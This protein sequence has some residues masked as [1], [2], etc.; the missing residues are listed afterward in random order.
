M[1]RELVNNV[2]TPTCAETCTQGREEAEYA[3]SLQQNRVWCLLGVDSA[4]RVCQ[5]V[6]EIQGGLDINRFQRAVCSVRDRHEILRT[7]FRLSPTDGRLM[8]IV[9]NSSRMLNSE[10]PVADLT[11]ANED[12]EISERLDSLRELAVDVRHGPLYRLQLLRHQRNRWVLLAMISALCGDLPTLW[13]FIAEVAD[14]YDRGPGYELRPAPWQYRSFGE[15]QRELLKSEATE[16]GRRYWRRNHLSDETRF[17]FPFRRR[18]VPN[19]GSFQSTTFPCIL[20]Q[21]QLTKLTA[22][23][24]AYHASSSEVLLALWLVLLWR[25]TGNDRVVVGIHSDGRSQDELRNAFGPYSTYLP[26]SC[27]L[28]SSFRFEDVIRSAHSLCMQNRRWQ[29]SFTWEH[30]A[31]SGIS[32]RQISLYSAL[33]EFRKLPVSPVLHD[34]SFRFLQHYDCLEPYQAKLSCLETS[35]GI[36]ISL[37]FDSSSF[38]VEDMLQ[39]RHGLHSLMG[40][41]LHDPVC[42]ISD[43]PLLADVEYRHLSLGLNATTKQ[44][45]SRGTIHELFEAR[46]ARSPDAIAAIYDDQ[47]ISYA[48]LNRRANSLACYLQQKGISQEVLV[49]LCVHRSIDMLVAIVAVLKAGGAYVPLDPTYPTSCLAQLLEDSR[50][51]FLVTD[52]SSTRNLP[53]VEIQSLCIDSEIEWLGCNGW[54]NPTTD[55]HPGNLVYVIYTSGSTGVPKGVAIEHRQLVNYS[56]AIVDKLGIVPGT[57]F[58]ALSTIAADL[59]NTA[60]FPSLISGGS[61]HLIPEAWMHDVTSLCDYCDKNQIDVLKI[62][63]SHLSA[64]QGT[65]KGDRLMPRRALLLGGESTTTVWIRQ[66]QAM[67]ASCRILNHY[68]P[69]ETTVG[70]L[71]YEVPPD[72]ESAPANPNTPLGAP[73]TNMLSYVLDGLLSPAPVGVIG[74]IYIGGEGV[75]RGYLGQPDKTA[76]KFIPNPYSEAPGARFYRTGDMAR[77][78]TDG[79]L[80]FLGRVDGQLKIRGFRIETGE[81]EAQL[82]AHPHVNNAVVLANENR[83]GHKRLVA[84]L[85][86]KPGQLL[87]IEDVSSYLATRVPTFMVPADYIFGT[88]PLTRNGKVDRKALLEAPKL[89]SEAAGEFVPPC[90]E[91][92]RDLARIWAEVLGLERV[93]TTANFFSLGGDSILSIQIVSRAVALGYVLTAKDVFEYQTIARL[94]TVAR[95]CER[96]RSG[97]GSATGEVCLTPIQSRFFETNIS[98]PHHWNQSVLLHAKQD[99]NSVVLEQAFQYLLDHHDSLRLRFTRDGSGVRQS[100]SEHSGSTAFVEVDLSTQK[101]GERTESLKGLTAEVHASLDLTKGPLLRIVKFHSGEAFDDLLLIVIHHLC[102]DVV[103]WHILLEDLQNVY[104]SLCKGEPP[105]LPAKTSSY[106]E[107][108]KHLALMA[109]SPDILQEYEYWLNSCPSVPELPLDYP[110]GINLQGSARTIDVFL[111][112]TA[113]Q[114]L[115]HGELEAYRLQIEDVLLTAVAHAFCRWT[116]YPRLLVDVENHGRYETSGIDLSR[117]VGWFTSV[118]PIL[119]DIGQSNKPEHSLRAIKEQLRRVPRRGLGYGLLRYLNQNKEHAEKLRSFPKPQVCFNYVG[120]LDQAFFRPSLFAGTSELEVSPYSPRGVRL[121][122]LEL[123]GRVSK[124]QMHFSFRYNESLHRQDTIERL[125]QDFLSSLRSIAAYCLVETSNGLT[126]SDFPDAALNQQELDSLV[127]KFG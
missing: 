23:S 114:I 49:A 7:T 8:Q 51:S 92:E 112:P 113:T 6:L 74:E 36:K 3:A 53:K 82:L 79:N 84:Y 108:A 66:L 78:R 120:Q 45:W 24:N 18:L 127:A 2:C 67:R 56:Q 35:E 58:A 46:V 122:L 42:Q 103:S 91:T 118:F 9:H 10:I 126:P 43:L 72:K 48:G 61:L 75:G 14:A 106:Q 89:K 1:A 105:L 54:C 57:G 20:D 55:V 39:L 50:A 125:S 63:P 81:I 26:L 80:D 111:D 33:F 86:P 96:F 62:T 52:S 116:G 37:H 41:A 102:T 85:E 69:T 44:D 31:S 34:S 119:L 101:P 115:L 27:E 97:Q 95:K 32:Q 30:L 83:S 68:G 15:W 117:T 87:Q 90:T 94:A 88:L 17:E 100:Y 107:W 25:L 11:A 21:N 123:I 40:A 110:K 4:P 77:R 109:D 64:L 65:A 104:K 19:G 59:G 22:V 124:G 29:D 60:I 5:Q 13:H 28:N 93:S 47:Q 70:A 38:D 16:S 12:W 73:L 121:H 71:L 76:A 98:E 99:L